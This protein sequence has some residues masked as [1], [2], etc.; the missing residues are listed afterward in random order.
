MMIR[1]NYEKSNDELTGSTG[2]DKFK[3]GSGSDKVLDF[4]KA[5]G[6]KA[7]GNC[8]NVEKGNGKK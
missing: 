7:T 4:N 2:A 3:C 6:D 1:L 8:E 5:Q